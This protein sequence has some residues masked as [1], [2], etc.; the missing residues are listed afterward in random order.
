[1]LK[2]QCCSQWGLKFETSTIGWIQILVNGLVNVAPN[3][4]DYHQLPC[5]AKCP[6]LGISLIFRHT[7]RHAIKQCV[8]PQLPKFGDMSWHVPLSL[9]G[10]PKMTTRCASQLGCGFKKY[11]GYNPATHTHFHIHFHIHRYIYTYIRIYVYTC[12][13]IYIYTH[14]Y[15]HTYIYMYIYICIFCILIL[16]MSKS[17]M[18]VYVSDPTSRPLRRWRHSEARGPKPAALKKLN[19]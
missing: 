19:D 6:C 4:L 10:C 18:C 16:H 17:Y 14:T 13:H 7:H 8:M 9:F 12:I 5:D 1:M 15:T 3:L 2:N 11:P